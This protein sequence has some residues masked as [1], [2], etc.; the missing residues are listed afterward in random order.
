V[1][2]WISSSSS[3]RTLSR[4]HLGDIVEI[5]S[6]ATG[7]FQ[8][9]WSVHGQICVVRKNKSPRCGKPSV[10]F[11]QATV[12]PTNAI[13]GKFTGFGNLDGAIVAR[14]AVPVAVR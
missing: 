5:N 6:K 10:S 13:R 8:S 1:R 3:G 11:F 14:I 2:L 12:G 4:V 7:D 9:E